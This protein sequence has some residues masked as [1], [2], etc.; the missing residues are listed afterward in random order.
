MEIRYWKG[1]IEGKGL[2]GTWYDVQM[3]LVVGG[4]IYT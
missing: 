4:G 1:K 2:E 3:R